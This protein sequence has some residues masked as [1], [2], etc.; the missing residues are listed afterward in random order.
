M[1]LEDEGRG[2]RGADKRLTVY[3]LPFPQNY[4]RKF[5]PLLLDKRMSGRIMATCTVGPV[6]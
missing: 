6:R 2:S 4:F 5:T 1:S 3:F